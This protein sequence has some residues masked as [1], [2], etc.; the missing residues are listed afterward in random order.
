MRTTLQT[1]VLVALIVSSV[2]VVATIFALSVQKQRA[3]GSIQEGQEYNAT[4][5]RGFAGTA[6]T[7]L[8]RLKGAGD[9]CISGSLARITVSGS[10]GPSVIRFWDA[11]TTNSSLRSS[12]YASSTIFLGEFNLLTATSTTLDLDQ[13]FSCGLIYELVSGSAATSSVMWR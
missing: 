2:L 5:T 11:T 1:K 10:A 7:N 9:A 12:F 8:T 4:S 6:L 3:L 13:R